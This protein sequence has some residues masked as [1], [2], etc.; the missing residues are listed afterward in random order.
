MKIS[1]ALLTLMAWLP[2]T[3]NAIVL[4]LTP[5]WEDEGDRLEVELSETG[6]VSVY[7]E[8]GADE[9]NLSFVIAFFD[10]TPIRDS[11]AIGYDVV[12]REFKM[13]RDDG[14]GWFRAMEWNGDRSIEQYALLAADDDRGFPHEQWGTDGPWEGVVDSIIIHG[15]E[16]GEYDLYF[17]NRWTVEPGHAARSPGL[18]SRDNR[19]FPSSITFCGH[20]GF[21][22]FRN[23]WADLIP[24]YEFDVPFVIGVT[25][26]PASILLLGVG[27]LS[28]AWRRGRYWGGGVGSGH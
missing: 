16:V 21:L 28:I 22:C 1:F 19:Q 4:S 15:T 6:V 24:G 5:N 27:M 20:P 10:A 8:I 17:E 12:G 25:P 3:A 23:A 26:E 18:F 11:D 2:V 14:S 13:Q 9:R 7:V